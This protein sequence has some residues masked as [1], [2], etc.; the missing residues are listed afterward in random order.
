MA[1]NPKP[2]DRPKPFKGKST[3]LTA[4]I[5]Q[6]GLI[7]GI[8]MV[9][10]EWSLL[11]LYLSYWYAL[12]VLGLES[13]DRVAQ[14]TVSE[15][16]ESLVNWDS[17]TRLLVAATKRRLDHRAS[18][19]LQKLLFRAKNAYGR[20]NAVVH[21]RW[22]TSAEEPGKWIHQ[23][24]MFG[25]AEVYDNACFRQISNDIGDAVTQLQRFFDGVRERLKS[26][27]AEALRSIMQGATSDAGGS[28]SATP[29]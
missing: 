1:E 21:G 4:T 12:M 28:S 19:D 10:I 18:K 22:S 23:K 14:V 25:E 2:P 26:P 3:L 24:S 13:E 16:L 27:Y 5:H 29:P 8:G 7:M 9:S 17:K 20:R 15:S 6:P 11:E